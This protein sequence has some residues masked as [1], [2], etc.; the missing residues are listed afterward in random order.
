VNIA[1]RLIQRVLRLDPPL[2]RDLIVQ[3]DLRVP[4]P[5]GVELLADRWAPRSGG[6]TLP[7][8]LLRSPYGRGKLIATGF[9]RPLAERGFQVLI[10]S[11]RGTFG[12]GGV[13]EPMRNERADGGRPWSGW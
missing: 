6:Q 13:F 1:S 9:V 2:T 5:D 4:M 7:L 8:A 11:T 12:S 3:R 10:Q